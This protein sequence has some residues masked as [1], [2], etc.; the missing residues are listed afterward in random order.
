MSDTEDQV[1]DKSGSLYSVHT[2]CKDL[3]KESSHSGKSQLISSFTKK[4]DGDL[5]LLAKLMLVKEDKRVFRLK[6][7]SMLKVCAHIWDADLD[8]M[9]ADLDNG[10]F[11]ET[12]KKFYIEYGKFP[13]RSTLTLKE[14]DDFL[15][16]LTKSGKFDDQVKLV[17]KI[18]KKCI[19]SD[20]RLI[21]RIIDGDLKVNTGA[22]FFLDGLHPNAYDFFKKANNLKAV[23]EKIQKH[24]FDKNNDDDMDDG[25]D[26]D[27]DDD[28]DDEDG[29]KKKKKKTSASKKNSGAFDSGIKL[30]TPIKPMLPKACKSVAEVVKS[31][32]STFYAEIKYDGERIQIHK[33]GNK[34]SCYSRNLKPMMPYKVEHVTEFIP[35]A[36]KATQMILDG[37]ILLMDTKTGIPLPFG[38]LSIHK[39]KD[40][41]D[42][43]VCIFLFD[44]LYLNGESLIHRPFHERREILEKN[45]KVVQHRVE[46]SEITKIQGAAEQNKLTDLLNRAFKEK[47][48]GLVVKDGDMEY[49]PGCRHWIKVKKD[50]IAGMGD[51]ADLLALGGYYGTG[52]FGGVIT[53]FLMCTWDKKTKTYKTVCKASSGIDDK[54]IMKM[55]P[56]ILEKMTKIS[57]D[58][59]KVPHWLDCAKQYTPDFIVKDYREAMVLEIGTAEITQTK[60]HTSGYS[61]RFPRILKVRHDK[62]YKTATNF[63]EL[64]HL[65]KDAK[66]V[67]YDDDD[68]DVVLKPSKKTTAVPKTTTTTTTT[69]TTST[70]S[71][72]KKVT[73]TI[74]CKPTIQELPTDSNLLLIHFGN[75]KL[76]S[77]YGLSKNI[78]QYFEQDELEQFSDEKKYKSTSGGTLT[79]MEKNSFT[80]QKVCIYQIPCIEKKTGKDASFNMELF[81]KSLVSLYTIC[82]SSNSK[83]VIFK[84]NYSEWDDIE[85]AI[86]SHD[87][88]I[89]YLVVEST[90]SKK[91]SKATSSTT[92]SSAK[93]TTDISSTTT[94]TTTTAGVELLEHEIISK[95]EE[96]E[97]DKEWPFDGVNV[98]FS[99]KLDKELVK[100]LKKYVLARRGKVSDQWVPGGINETT[101]FIC[102]NDDCPMFTHVDRLGGIIVQSKWI[103]E[104]FLNDEK[105]DEDLY[106]FKPVNN[107]NNN[108]SDNSNSK[109]KS[110]SSSK[111]KNNGNSSNGGNISP[112]KRSREEEE[113][114][115]EKDNTNGKERDSVKI[116]T[117]HPTIFKNCNIYLHENINDKEKLRRYIIAFYGQISEHITDKTTHIVISLPPNFSL[118]PKEYIYKQLEKNITNQK[119][120]KIPV[121]N[122]LWIWDSLN[123]EKLLDESKYILTSK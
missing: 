108:N 80:K 112:N 30:M 10:D 5:Y 89:D 70:S 42:A 83:A 61:L 31:C 93:D 25:D 32:G 78:T 64:Q 72:S 75:P 117:I 82:D 60:H 74:T 71:A 86:Q 65:G 62:D 79:H 100:K 16:G 101:H 58:H 21:C 107:N 59:T 41:K 76:W 55:Q 98:V 119:N 84:Q 85:H 27:D 4:F 116:K 56:G 17:K 92:S 22:K 53:V 2:L 43:T 50:Y 18:L 24:D 96:M 12:C 35:K 23:I 88:T 102:D 81:K 122:S 115:D 48:E 54:T 109:D 91:N 63:E 104:C 36:T 40:F 44:I 73:T 111:D 51:T 7:K 38:T 105:V 87:E 95:A 121:L 106:I 49:E 3:E 90:K 8:E 34:F 46:F 6:D 29:K 1:V 39:K 11:T 103:E 120:Q 28:D 69:T 15:E 57:K 68:E 77:Q 97:K 37:E 52:N 66:I 94:T 114:H 26:D 9:I 99:D 20:W 113:D 19:P 123:S 33:D 47:L 118:K 14:V 13:K 110:S 45:I 67:S